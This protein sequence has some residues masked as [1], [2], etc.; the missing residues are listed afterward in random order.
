MQHRAR[1]R[2]AGR[3]RASR[4]AVSSTGLA[5]VFVGGNPVLD[6]TNTVGWTAKGPSNERLAQYA[7]LVSWAHR[8]GILDR[9]A[10]TAL[11]A[12]ARRA[13][14]QAARALDRALHARSVLHTYLISAARRE[15]SPAALDQEF[16]ALL[17]TAM[18]KLRVAPDDAAFQWRIEGDHDLDVITARLI[19]LAAILLTGPER[20]RLG[21]CASSDCGWL[22]LDETKNHSRR[23]C[24]M[25]DCGNRAKARRYYWRKRG[26][27]G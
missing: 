4:P 13:G 9:S 3:Q 22:Y 11:A 7:D 19:W 25:S 21:C 14:G 10:A 18:T 6:F 27:K 1:A 26:R 5:F 16:N 24:R 15:R 2:R 17:R 12:Y 23:W 20:P 8:V